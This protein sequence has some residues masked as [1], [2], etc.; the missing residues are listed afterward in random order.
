MELFREIYDSIFQ[1]VRSPF[2]GYIAVSFVFLNWKP[3]YYLTFADVSVLE[4]FTYFDQSSDYYSLLILPFILGVALALLAPYISNFGSWWAQ[5]PTANRKLREIDLAH[6]LASKKGELLA[7][8][9]KQRHIVEQALLEGAQL[10]QEAKSLDDD[11]REELESKISQVRDEF[12]D[13]I[14]ALD[15]VSQVDPLGSPKELSDVVAQVN[16]NWES[17]L[18][19]RLSRNGQ[20][21]RAFGLIE[22]H[23]EDL[24]DVMRSVPSNLF[25]PQDQAPKGEVQRK[26]VRVVREGDVV[27][28][29]PKADLFKSSLDAMRRVGATVIQLS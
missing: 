21:G 23:N 9:D 1:R 7:E 20:R 26:L 27:F 6:Q 25:F 15:G 5:S 28:V 22:S 19:T 13:S 17:L 11:V 18:H 12:Y 8:R 14:G 29:S 2:W 24:P 10:D 3:L 16:A 4:R